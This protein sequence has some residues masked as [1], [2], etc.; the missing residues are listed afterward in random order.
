MREKIVFDDSEIKLSFS[1]RERYDSE[2]NTCFISLCNSD[3]SVTSLDTPNCH[4]T[5]PTQRTTRNGC[6]HNGRLYNVGE[7][8]SNGRS[9]NWCFGSFCDESGHVIE[10]DNFN[11]GTTM[12]TPSTTSSTTS[13]PPTTPTTTEGNRC[14]YDGIYYQAG[15]VISKGE[16]K[17]GNWCYGAV[18]SDSGQ[19]LYW[20]DFNC[21]PTTVSPTTRK[22]TPPPPT[23]FARKRLILK[24]SELLMNKISS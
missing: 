7:T 3:G 14:F 17:D 5:P 21:F 2:T 1:V 11:C 8:I 15:T 16:D 19:V 24:L 9:G 18:C 10:W 20:D 13:T 23:A 6:Y 4:T 22:I 12:T